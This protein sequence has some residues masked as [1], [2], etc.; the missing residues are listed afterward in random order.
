[1]H[2]QIINDSK[3]RHVVKGHALYC[4]VAFAYIFSTEHCYFKVILYIEDEDMLITNS[5]TVE[6]K[7]VKFAKSCNKEHSEWFVLKISALF[8]G[9]GAEEA[10]FCKL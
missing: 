10:E 3:G 2:V 1:M 5:L 8:K 6:A 4:D 9:L 7:L